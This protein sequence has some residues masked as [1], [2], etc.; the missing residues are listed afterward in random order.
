MLTALYLLCLLHFSESPG[1][2][3]FVISQRAQVH[4]S[5]FPQ[6]RDHTP[7]QLV[8]PSPRP[9]RSFFVSFQAREGPATCQER[10]KVKWRR[11]RQFDLEPIENIWRQKILLF[12][13]Y[14]LLASGRCYRA[15]KGGTNHD[16][17]SF[18]PTFMTLLSDS[19][20][21]R[22]QQIFTSVGLFSTMH[23]GTSGYDRNYFN[24]K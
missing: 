5:L 13:E 16:K 23:L 19:S 4:F 7:W 21:F 6:V 17:L 2:Q 14:K 20:T 1:N 11:W 15:D 24:K 3:P 9:P 22:N 10:S 8:A 18:H 12:A